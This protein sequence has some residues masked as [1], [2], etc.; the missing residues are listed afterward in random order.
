M[1]CTARV[2]KTRAALRGR[3]SRPPRARALAGRRIS[4]PRPRDAVAGQAHADRQPHR[5][6][7]RGEFPQSRAQGAGDRARHRPRLDLGDDRQSR[8]DRPLA[9]RGAARHAHDRNQRR[10]GRDRSR[11]PRGQRRRIRRRRA[12]AASSASTACPKTD[13]SRHR[14][15]SNIRY[16]SPAARTCRSMSASRRPTAT[17]PGRARSI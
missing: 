6:L 10:V 3:R 2:V 12:R 9:R 13:W 16:A 1:C 14:R 5:A 17:R 8:R 11:L 4:R 7:R 15:R